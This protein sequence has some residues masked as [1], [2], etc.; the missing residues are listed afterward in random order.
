[1]LAGFAEELEEMR[2]AEKA[3]G[4]KPDPA[5]DAFLNSQT[6]EGA[7]ES[8]VTDY[9][10]K[11]LGLDVSLLLLDTICKINGVKEHKTLIQY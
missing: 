5:M 8:I 11:I 10:L 3:S 9:M 1:M 7:K 6:I 4:R 2:L